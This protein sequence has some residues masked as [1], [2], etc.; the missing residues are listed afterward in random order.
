MDIAALISELLEHESDLVVPGLGSFYR[1][2]VEGYYSKEQ[3]QFYPPTLQL[4]FN[5][6]LKEDDGKL[7]AWLAENQQISQASATY[8]LERFVSQLIEQL[9]IDSV[10]IG[11]LGTFSMRRNE[12]AFT[13]RRL[14]NNNELFYGLAPVKL[15][16][17]QTYNQADEVSKPAVQ[18]PVTEKPSDFTAALLRGEPMPGKPLSIITGGGDTQQVDDE[19]GAGEKPNRIG[20]WVL[21]LAIIILV[22]G[23]GLIGAYK[24]KPALFDKFRNQN[25]PPPISEE[26][27]KK[28]VSDS[29]Q[30][31][32]QAQKDIGATPNVDSV[33]KSKIMAPETPVDTF[34]IVLSQFSTLNGVKMESQRLN[35][36]GILTDIHKKP[37]GNGYQL[38][39]T[40]YTSLDSANKYLEG[41]KV[42]FRDPKIFIQTYPYKAQ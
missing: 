41:Y 29:I 13:P 5:P 36:K 30:R 37:K 1:S 15:R 4:Q 28:L 35:N 23:L 19:D 33:T 10:A 32:I 20:T 38:D 14:S 12:V 25:Q 31:A 39:I 18:I 27:R 3:Q 40:T 9:Q 26:K 22:S 17:N 6:D 7:V 11:D 8:F 16:R 21:V 42:K 2:R 24:Y 34:G